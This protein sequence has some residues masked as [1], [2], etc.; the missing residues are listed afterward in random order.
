VERERLTHPPYIMGKSPKILAVFREIRRVASK[1]LPV[2]ISGESGTYK[3]LVARAIHDNSPRQESPFIAVNLSSIPERFA[4]AELFGGEKGTDTGAHER[5]VGRIREANGGTLFLYEIS[6][7]DGDTQEMLLSFLQS[8][9]CRT[10]PG[11]SAAASN[12]RMISSTSKNLKEGMSNGH[13]RK[14]LCDLLSVAHIKI[15]PL[16]DRGED[17][18]P[19]ARYFLK[20]AVTKFETGPKEFSKEA[21]D[22]LVDYEWP[23]NIRELENTVRKAVIL[24]SDSVI[25]KKDLLVSDVG[26]CSIEEFLEEKLK[27]YLKEMMKLERCNLY[28]TVL[29]EVE[30]SLI[31][32][33]LKETGGNQLRAAKALGINRNTLRA[34]IKEYK[35]HV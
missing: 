25:G 9:E 6:D 34:K 26:S 24:S 22:F 33:I 2:L 18:L 29:S 8:N 1:N 7:L 19:I 16:R 15:P 3:E 32:I 11:D 21:K 10:R 12:V 27:R 4:L 30:K 20:E 13:L 31:H 14:D 23:G 17:I 35:I 28:E 5:K